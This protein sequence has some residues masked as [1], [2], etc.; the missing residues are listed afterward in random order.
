MADRGHVTLL[1]QY[2]GGSTFFRR[3]EAEG[4]AY[5]SQLVRLANGPSTWVD[6]AWI[7]PALFPEARS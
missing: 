3:A 4:I 1:A 6:L 7:A 5:A 2:S